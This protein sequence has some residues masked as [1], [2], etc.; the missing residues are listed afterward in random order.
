MDMQ[1]LQ[2]AAIAPDQEYEHLV[3]LTRSMHALNHAFRVNRNNA[4]VKPD[5]LQTSTADH[6]ALMQRIAAD[7]DR[8]AFAVLFDYFAPRVK[9]Y[10]I[11]MGMGSA[12]AEDTAQDVMVSMWEKAHLFDPKKAKLSTW[13]YRIARNKFIDLTR[14]HRFPTVD[15]EDHLTE[16]EAPE[17]TDEAAII[18]QESHA[19]SQA[20]SK[21]SPEQRRVIETSFF[22][23][24]S[25]S[26]VS[27][28]LSIPLGTVKSRLRLAFKT[29]R[30][31]LDNLR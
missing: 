14:K 3:R 7:Q 22:K 5:M 6:E 25:H 27:E 29:L 30:K 18:N 21:L 16:L 1:V 13:L 15:A 2:R 9:S 26:E 23:D 12:A 4:G 31:E 11:K 8:A 10:L 17:S 28:Q 19:V 20:M 24:L